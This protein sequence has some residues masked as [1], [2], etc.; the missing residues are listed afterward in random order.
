MGLGCGHSADDTAGQTLIS[1]GNAEPDSIGKIGLNGQW[2]VGGSLEEAYRD[3][4]ER[5]RGG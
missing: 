4:K 2:F 3:G 1:R 5:R